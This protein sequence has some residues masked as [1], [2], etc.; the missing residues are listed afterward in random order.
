MTKTSIDCVFCFCSQEV[1]SPSLSSF[2]GSNHPN[3]TANTPGGAQISTSNNGGGGQS[4]LP[5]SI[6]QEMLLPFNN[7]SPHD[8]KPSSQ[9]NSL[10]SVHHLT[11]SAN[12]KLATSPP[13]SNPTSVNSSAV[14][15]GS[16]NMHK[17]GSTSPSSENV[18]YYSGSHNTKQCDQTSKGV[19]PNSQQLTGLASLESV[20][21]NGNNKKS[22]QSANSSPGKF[23]AKLFMFRIISG[24][25]TRFWAHKVLVV[26][27]N[28]SFNPVTNTVGFINARTQRHRRDTRPV[29]LAGYN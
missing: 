26:R 20:D 16:Q 13:H 5:N 14:M 15:N 17:L 6:K 23:N 28:T 21:K 2:Q 1:L 9:T 24:L 12:H 27:N 25:R 11:S 8:P 19:K 18:K 10:P 3:S 29:L 7:S 22:S 4:G